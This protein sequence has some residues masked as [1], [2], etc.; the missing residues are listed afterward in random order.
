VTPDDDGA[1]G[2]RSRDGRSA[3]V[4]AT[5]PGADEDVEDTV[6]AT[7]A[8]TAAAQRAHPSVRIEQFGGGSAS[9]ALNDALKEDFQRAEVLSLPIT[10]VILVV[11]FGALVAAGSRCSSG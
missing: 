5:L 1:A 2:L 10:L 7:L 4:T 3:L 9:K 6:D 8:A 11:A